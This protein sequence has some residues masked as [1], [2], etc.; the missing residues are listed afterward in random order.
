MY[1]Q[2]RDLLEVL[3]GTTEWLQTKCWSCCICQVK[4]GWQKIS[5]S[6]WGSWA[7][8]DS[9]GG[10]SWW[11]SGKEGGSQKLKGRVR[12]QRLVLKVVPKW[13]NYAALKRCR[14]SERSMI[15]ARSWKTAYEM[16]IEWKKNQQH[17]TESNLCLPEI[18]RRIPGLV[19]CYILLWKTTIFNGKTH[20]KWPCSIAFC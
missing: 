17:G 6:S 3:P 7:C 15:S 13:G 8:R 2:G 19:N 9:L 16:R 10:W 5:G 12:G 18:L 20:Y 14:V 1:L 11:M 4:L